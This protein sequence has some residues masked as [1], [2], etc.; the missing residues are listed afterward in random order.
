MQVSSCHGE[1]NVTKRIL[2]Q[3][4]P[5]SNQLSECSP[6]VDIVAGLALAGLLVP[7]GMAYA[8]IA[9]V[10]PQMGLYAALAP[11]FLYAMFG[12]SRQLAVSAT[13]SSRPC[14]LRSWHQWLW[15]MQA[16][17]PCWLRLPPWQQV[18]FSCRWFVEVRISIGVRF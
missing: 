15:G 7:E 16:A 10:P 13:S 18:L 12:I 8:G 1:M 9:G 3:V 14:S 6:R 11:M 4:L 2:F 5:I 17:M